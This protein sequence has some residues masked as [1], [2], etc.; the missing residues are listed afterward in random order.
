[1][2]NEEFLISWVEKIWVEKDF[3]AAEALIA[4]G[5]ETLQLGGEMNLKANDYET[6]VT[7]MSHNFKAEK[8]VL[9]EVVTD[10]PRIS[11]Y[12]GVQGRRIDD[13]GP[14]TLEVHVYREIKDGKVVA[15]RSTCDY[16]TFFA[17]TGQI[18]SDAIA[19]L[20]MGGSLVEL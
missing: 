15:S 10:G 16:L 8:V 9:S 5:T 19:T 7:A 11:G 14:I 1:M 13:G 4:P 20:M 18:P 3:K 6:M 17:A 2:T 12:I